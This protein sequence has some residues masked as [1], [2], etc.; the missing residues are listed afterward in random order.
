MGGDAAVHDDAVLRMVTCWVALTPRGIDAPGLE[1]VA[2]HVGR[3]LS[4]TQLTD[5]AVEQHWP[6]SRRTRP[7]LEAGDVVVFTG[8]VLHR[9]HVTSAMTPTRTSI[10]LRGFHGDAIPGRLAH[11]EFVAVPAP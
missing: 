7:A 9:T 11:D 6:T 5:A 3:M 2:D 1:L 4:P 8:D 10:E